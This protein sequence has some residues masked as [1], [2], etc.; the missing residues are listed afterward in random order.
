MTTN[1]AAATAHAR[2]EALAAYCATPND[3]TWTAYGDE[4]L[5]LPVHASVA[6]MDRGLACVYL[7]YDRATGLAQPA[8]R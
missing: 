8:E 7:P 1:E 4:E 6:T 3:I 5:A 2:T